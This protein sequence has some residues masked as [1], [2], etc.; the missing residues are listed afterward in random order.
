MKSVL[1]TRSFQENQK[2]ICNTLSYSKKIRFIN[3]PLIEYKPLVFNLDNLFI[4]NNIIITSK[5]AA[6]LVLV[7]LLEKDFSNILNRINFW[8]VGMES[9][10]L[11]KKI[12][13]K[14]KYVA[15]NI[16]DLM[17][18]LPKDIW[19]STV[20]LCG[21]NI[22]SSLNSEI[23][24]KIV[25]EVAYTD[26]IKESELRDIREYGAD[27]ILLYSSNCTRVLI[28][29]LRNHN[30]LDSLKS[31]TLVIAISN[32]VRNLAKKYFNNVTYCKNHSSK[33]MINLLFEL[34][35]KKV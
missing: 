13:T 8:L 35:N 2:I 30:N 34:I 28:S 22:T 25:Y 31:S 29:L 23:T 24:T 20:Y 4:Y 18:N 10:S 1:L 16:N 12:N 17:H 5:Y 7:S 3:F 14:I 32:K 27:Y 26:K 33:E 11:L 19:R 6:S 9:F 15:K 21:N